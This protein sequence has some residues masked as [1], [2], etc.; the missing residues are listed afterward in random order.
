ML[1]SVRIANLPRMERLSTG[2]ACEETNQDQGRRQLLHGKSDHGA[3]MDRKRQTQG[4]PAAQW[5]LS[6]QQRGLQALPRKL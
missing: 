4:D 2:Y 3:E 1:Q 5:S 6:H